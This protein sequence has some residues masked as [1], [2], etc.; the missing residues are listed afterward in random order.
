MKD[1]RRSDREL[2]HAIG[3]SQPTVSRVI[4]KLEK[5][6][7]IREYTIIPDFKKLGYTLAS[8]TFINL[9][10]G[11]TREELQK[12]R[13]TTTRDLCEDCPT[14]IVM[15]ERGMGIG[16]TGVIIAM[17]KNYSSYT[18]LKDR[19]KKYDFIEHLQTDSFI[20]DLQDEVHYRYLTFSTLAKN[21]LESSCAVK[22]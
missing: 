2:A 4:A 8:M 12:A 6:R 1:S 5:Q 22:Q 3:V 17:H 11:L 14:E 19:I 13:E 7:V 18:K 21:L 10:S 15:F 16:F 20:I 9:K